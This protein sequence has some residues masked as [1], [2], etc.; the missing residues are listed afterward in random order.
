MEVNIDEYATF[1]GLFV[2]GKPPGVN[3]FIGH[4]TANPLPLR[5]F[6]TTLCEPQSGAFHGNI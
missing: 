1:Q 3:L 4:Y 5:L 6:M 2:N